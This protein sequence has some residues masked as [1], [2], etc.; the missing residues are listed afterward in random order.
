VEIDLPEDSA[1]SLMGIYPKDALPCQRVPCPTMFIAALFIMNYSFLKRIFVCSNWFF[2]QHILIIFFHLSNTPRP[3]HLSTP[4]D[5]FLLSLSFKNYRLLGGKKHNKMYN[6]IKQKP[7]YSNWTRQPNR[8]KTFPGLDLLIK[9]SLTHILRN[10]IKI[11]VCK[12]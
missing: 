6:K 5:T 3:P 9:D 12:L 7:S 11:L 4:L 10:S 8:K 2:I 1:I